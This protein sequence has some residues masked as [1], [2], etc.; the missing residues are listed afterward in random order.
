MSHE[1]H[2]ESSGTARGRNS[3]DGRPRSRSVASR[4]SAILTG[5]AGRS[6]W[7]MTEVAHHTRLP[8]STAHR[9][10]GELVDCGFLH[11]GADGRYHVGAVLHRVAG[12]SADPATDARTLIAECLDDLESVTGCRARF[13]TLRGDGVRYLELADG[14]PCA[15]RGSAPAMAPAH[16]T[17]AGKALLAHAGPGVLQSFIQRGFPRYTT[18]TIV[19]S[20]QLQQALALVLQR[21]FAVAREEWKEAHCAIAAPVLRHGVR[22]LGALELTVPDAPGTARAA[23]PAL[24]V[25]ARGLARR[26]AESADDLPPAVGEVPL[27][28]ARD[29]APTAHGRGLGIGRARAHA[30]E[31]RNRRGS[32]H[33]RTPDTRPGC[34]G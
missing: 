19:T 27:W 33:G 32:I 8:V 13:A 10:M 5:F 6:G 15:L 20:D 12:G 30:Y 2:E 11:R 17:A 1:W 26:L 7:T 24:V 22:L 23:A 34:T 21:N 3:E 29:A 31:S 25:A 4:I 18:R 16:A 28:P 9:L 14:S